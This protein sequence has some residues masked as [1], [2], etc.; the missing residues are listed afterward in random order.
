MM[1]QFGNLYA[2]QRT[3]IGLLGPLMN[4]GIRRFQLHV[5]SSA[6]STRNKSPHETE[7]AELFLYL[8]VTLKGCLRPCLQQQAEGS[9]YFS[10]ALRL[11]GSVAPS[12]RG[13]CVTDPLRRCEFELLCFITLAFSANRALRTLR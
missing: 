5:N 2:T 8:T 1:K 4:H 9:L 13:Q 7:P 12:C 10:S 3:V 11:S 6:E